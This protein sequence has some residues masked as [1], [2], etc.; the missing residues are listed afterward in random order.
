[1]SSVTSPVFPKW[2]RDIAHLLPIRSQFVLSGNIRDQVFVADEHPRMVSARAALWQVLEPLGFDGLLVW[3]VVDGL[4]AYPL[5]PAR[6]TILNG[7]CKLNLE[8]PQPMGLK[9]LASLVRQVSAPEANS[10]LPVRVALVIDYASRL[11]EDGRTPDD[12]RDFFVAAEKAANEAR[13][14]PRA[15][16]SGQKPLFN[17]V[18]WLVNRPNDLPYWLTVDNERVHSIPVAL[19]DAET[20]KRA[21]QVLYPLIPECR[22]DI[23]IDAFAASL[24]N[25]TDNMSVNALRDIV[26]LAVRLEIEASNIDDAVQSFRV[27]DMSMSSPW[28][29]EHLR[30]AISKGEFQIGKRVKG[31]HKAVIKVLDVLKRIPSD[32]GA[33]ARGSA[34]RPRGVLFFAGPTGVGKTEMAKAIAEAVFGDESAYLRFDMSEFSAEHSGDRLIGAPPGYVGFDQGGELTNAMRERPFRVLLFDEIEKA[35]HRILDKFLQVLEDGRL[36][37]GRGET[38]YFSDA[39]IIFTSNLGI[40]RKRRIG[41][42]EVVEI[43][44]SIKDKLSPDEFEKKIMAGVSRPLRAR[45]PTPEL[46]TASART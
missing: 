38:V 31:Q 20:R 3:D 44:V 23:A 35:H 12:A 40:S 18:I 28:R 43:L 9:P 2:L 27:G 42:E 32:T 15:P 25:L 13:P 45:A 37:D 6:L 8:Q 10:K 22:R 19:P 36:T 41:G 14:I 16:E 5:E 4:Q 17:P 21:A 29:G 24:V 46:S 30:S 39:L 11:R 26:S 34:S 1:M 33:Q 7:V